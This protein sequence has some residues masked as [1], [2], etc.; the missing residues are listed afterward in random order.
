MPPDRV[1]PETPS[2]RFVN[3]R[4]NSQRTELRSTFGGDSLGGP[5]W[6]P[7][8]FELEGKD[9]SVPLTDN[10]RALQEEVRVLETKYRNILEKVCCQPKVRI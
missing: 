1:S 8:L 10:S 2:Q 6:A 3:S 5:R 4:L 7:D 9:A